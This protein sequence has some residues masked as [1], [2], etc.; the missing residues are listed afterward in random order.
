MPAWTKPY[1]PYLGSIEHLGD[2]RHG[3]RVVVERQTGYVEAY[4]VHGTRTVSISRHPTIKK[5]RAWA[6]AEAQR[7]R[8][9]A[10]GRA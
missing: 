6:E 1:L 7:L 9:K 5:A 8:I 2:V 3:W 10:E 4:V